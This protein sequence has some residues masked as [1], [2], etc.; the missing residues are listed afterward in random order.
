M[1]VSVITCPVCGHQSS[2]NMSESSCLYF[3]KCK[4]CNEVIRPE[5]KDCCVFCTYGD[6]PC[7][8]V[9]MEDSGV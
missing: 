3:W 7:P 1:L 9:Q 6:T 2:E 4:A 5:N 8:P